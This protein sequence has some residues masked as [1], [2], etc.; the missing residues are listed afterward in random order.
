VIN[1]REKILNTVKGK[2]FL[3]ALLFALLAAA[4][5]AVNSTILKE[6]LTQE[7]QQL[8]LGEPVDDVTEI[9]QATEPETLDVAIED[10]VKAE[11]NPTVMETPA[12][13]TKEI[14][15]ETTE[16]KAAQADSGKVVASLPEL[17]FTLDS[18]MDWPI[19]GNVVLDYSMEST[20]YFPTLD[21]Y[22]CNPA[23]LIQ[24]E[25]S[26]PV[27]ATIAGQVTEIGHNEE[28]GQYVVLD[29]GNSFQATYGQL[30]DISVLEGDYV[31]A[32]KVL[33]YIAEPS[34]YY[35][36]EGSHLYFKVTQDG[37]PIDPMDVIQ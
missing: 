36:V 35:V 19:R 3:G 29:L 6:D 22:K 14:A 5:V 27:T 18:K 7:D 16:A 32:G 4:I 30:K 9:A 34:K 13:P 31:T 15:A 23:V 24:G 1:L 28:I 26:S 12:N 37:N 10:L 2:V 33:G 11:T 25:V 17:N 21:Q 20:I 8:N